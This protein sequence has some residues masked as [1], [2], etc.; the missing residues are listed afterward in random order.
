MP[1][2]VVTYSSPARYANDGN[3]V[4]NS[5][6]D[7]IFLLDLV[8]QFNKWSGIH[9]NFSKCNITAFIHDLQAIPR[10]RDIDDALRARLA[11]VILAGRPIGSLTQDEPL[12]GDFLGTSLTASLC[13]DA[14]FRWTKE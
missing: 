9:L 14:H 1:S 6:E 4:T 2:L 11:H 8:N 3:L 7:M 10:R 12:P 13:P 5:V